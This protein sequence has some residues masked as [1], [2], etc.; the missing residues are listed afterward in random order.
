MK[1]YLL[2]GAHYDVECDG[3]KLEALWDKTQD[4]EA[5]R[6]EYI[7]QTGREPKEMTVLMRLDPKE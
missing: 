7:A 6:K 2:I 3:E 5:V 1:K 4:A